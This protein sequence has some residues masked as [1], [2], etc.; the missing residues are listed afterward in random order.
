MVLY[1]LTPSPL[2]VVLHSKLLTILQPMSPSPCVVHF[3]I[4]GFNSQPYLY[5]ST[6]STPALWLL[7]T[8]C[9]HYLPLV[10]FL[11]NMNSGNMG[12]CPYSSGL[13][14]THV[15]GTVSK[16]GRFEVAKSGPT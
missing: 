3:R 1:G 10:T 11:V 8:G 9:D 14:P 13:R 12:V 7:A 6:G 4:E 2:E 5:T 16:S 15:P